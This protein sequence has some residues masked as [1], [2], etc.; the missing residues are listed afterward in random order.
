MAGCWDGINIKLMTGG[1][2][3]PALKMIHTARAHH[4]KVMLGCMI[5]SSLAIT[6]AAPLSPLVD[7]A[8]LDG[9]LLV[10]D[11]PFRGV[12]VQRGRLLLPDAPGL[13]VHR[14]AA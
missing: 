9:A 3:H 4:L 7:F 12:T 8:D 10:A 13:G 11:D 6:A 5:E 1:G 2:I 14:Q